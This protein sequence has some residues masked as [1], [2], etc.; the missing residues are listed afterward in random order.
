M[1]SLTSACDT[2]VNFATTRIYGILHISLLDAFQYLGAEW[3]ALA[4]IEHRF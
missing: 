1:K 4:P 3:D 2:Q